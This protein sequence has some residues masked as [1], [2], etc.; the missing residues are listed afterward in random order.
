MNL[1]IVYCGNQFLMFI[2]LAVAHCHLVVF[3]EGDNDNDNAAI[4]NVR[5][6]SL[7]K[8]ERIQ[9][10]LMAGVKDNIQGSLPILHSLCFLLHLCI[11]CL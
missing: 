10:R 11:I 5:E 3:L 6:K 1:F 9:S 2:L 7:E 4:K 8:G